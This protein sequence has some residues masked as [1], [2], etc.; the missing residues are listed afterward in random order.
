MRGNLRAGGTFERRCG[1]FGAGTVEP[2]ALAPTK[3]RIRIRVHTVASPQWLTGP[4]LDQAPTVVSD[5]AS[6]ATTTTQPGVTIVAGSRVAVVQ[7]A[8]DAWSDESE[9]GPGRIR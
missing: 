7:R 1:V 8:Y 9:R 6:P 3:F 5:D 4:R 2:G